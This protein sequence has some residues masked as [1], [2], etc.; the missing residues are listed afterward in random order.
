MLAD[1]LARA[2]AAVAVARADARE[3]LE[4]LDRVRGLGG[5]EALPPVAAG[6]S[7]A[8]ANLAATRPVIDPPPVWPGL[9]AE[10]GLSVGRG[11]MP[12]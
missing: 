11:R 5:T 2:R 3:L 8:R 9:P 10:Q 6:V 7:R 1:E 4:E 12:S